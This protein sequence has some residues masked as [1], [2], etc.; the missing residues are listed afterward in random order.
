MS[1]VSVGTPYAATATE[2]RY[3]NATGELVLAVFS[4]GR[5]IVELVTQPV[6]YLTQESRRHR[7]APGD[8]IED[9]WA[10]AASHHWYESS[11]GVVPSTRPG[12]VYRDDA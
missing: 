3:D 1:A 4:R 2:S 9:R 10:V 12:V 8:V 6:R 5:E 11:F 7:L